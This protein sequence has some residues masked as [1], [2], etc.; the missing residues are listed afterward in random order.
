MTNRAGKSIAT[1]NFRFAGLDNRQA[2]DIPRAIQVRQRDESRHRLRR[3]REASYSPRSQWHRPRSF[4]MSPRTMSILP[5]R[6]FFTNS[7]SSCAATRCTNDSN[8]KS[9]TLYSFDEAYTHRVT[10][11]FVRHSLLRHWTLGIRRFLRAPV[12]RLTKSVRLSCVTKSVVQTIGAALPEFHR[13]RFEPITAPVRRQ[14]NRLVA[15]SVRSSSAMRA[16][17]TR[18]PS[19]TSLWRDAHALNWLP[20]GRE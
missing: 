11:A 10:L 9:R 18:R 19:S 6:S 5:W 2:S 12:A 4:V 20:I 16:S 14:W 8:R 15:E 1:S 3:R 7:R 17:S 13:I